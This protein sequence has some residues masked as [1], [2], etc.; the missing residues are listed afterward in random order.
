MKLL[1]VRCGIRGFRHSLL[2]SNRK[3][4]SSWQD[5]C[6]ELVKDVG[7][8]SNCLVREAFSSADVSPEKL[9]RK[10]LP[11]VSQG[12]RVGVGPG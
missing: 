7:K 2:H 12:Q 1:C 6:W 8:K 10:N 9:V 3:T 5:C 4:V 11:A